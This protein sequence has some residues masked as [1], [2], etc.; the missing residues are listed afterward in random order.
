MAPP[1]PALSR[2]APV[3]RGPPRGARR[4]A[5]LPAPPG[6]G[7]APPCPPRG[8]PPPPRP[9]VGG[10]CLAA[11]PDMPK[12]VAG[13]GGLA[14]RAGPVLGWPRPRHALRA[15]PSLAF[16]RSVR[17]ARCRSGRAAGAPSRLPGGL[18]RSG[19]RSPREWLLVFALRARARRRRTAEEQTHGP[20]EGPALL[21]ITTL[22]ASF[23]CRA[24]G[25]KAAEKIR[26]PRTSGGGTDRPTVANVGPVW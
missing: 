16:G 8:R 17:S 14:C 26:P 4:P 9:P 12:R 1:C 23:T 24:V 5:S 21:T 20:G 19:L 3:G 10:A 18:G 22:A 6:G 15:V 2:S 13:R 25:K 7:C 11:R